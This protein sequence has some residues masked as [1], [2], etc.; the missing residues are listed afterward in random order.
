MNKIN[1]HGCV[2]TKSKARVESAV[3]GVAVRHR[4][5]A[6]TVTRCQLPE[7]CAT[8]RTA[9]ITFIR[10]GTVINLFIKQL[11]AHY[12]RHHALLVT[13]DKVLSNKN[14]KK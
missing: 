13:I 4:Q 6:S 2:H 8:V 1:E 11:F 3:N 9:F 5:F 7:P 10:L 14:P 12:K